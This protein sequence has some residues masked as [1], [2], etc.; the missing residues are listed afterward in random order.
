MNVY[1]S[2]T[3]RNRS[4]LSEQSTLKEREKLHAYLTEYL[5]VPVITQIEDSLYSGIYFWKIDSHLSSEG[6][7]LRTK[8]IIRDL[9]PCLKEQ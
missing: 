6:Q 5:R 9:E 3:P 2:Y 4:S 8:Q 1:F 7:L